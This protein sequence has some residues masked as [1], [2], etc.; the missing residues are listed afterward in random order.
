MSVNPSRFA[1]FAAQF[2]DNN[3]VIL[4]GGKIYTYGA[5]TTS[6]QT[7]YT[8][9]LGNTAHTNP[10]ILDSAGR[11]PGGEIWLTDNLFYKF[12][13]ESSNGV[14]IGTY[15]NVFGAIT[16]A[17]QVFDANY[18]TLDSAISAAISRNQTLYITLDHTVSTNTTVACPVVVDG[19]SFTVLAARTLTFTRGLDAG[20]NEIFFGAGLVTGLR[21][22]AAEWWGARADDTGDASIGWNKANACR[23]SAGLTG[24]TVGEWRHRLN[25]RGTYRFLSTAELHVSA[26]VGLRMFG[27]G[28]LLQTI[29]KAG[30]GS[31]GT[32]LLKIQLRFRIWIRL[33]LLTSAAF[34]LLRKLAPQ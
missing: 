12:V 27:G 14:L 9:S 29:L 18:E 16:S 17:L 2:F 10:I 8:N 1:G 13:V 25:E 34:R 19:G 33:L 28:P 20:W 26:T 21:D 32:I 5:G 30:S 11:V 22:V 23:M 4:S 6:P 3:G 31:T 7:T 15:D 24:T